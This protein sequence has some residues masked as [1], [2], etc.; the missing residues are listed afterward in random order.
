VYT[1]V[2]QERREDED[3]RLYL[4]RRAHAP[5]KERVVKSEPK[6]VKSELRSQL[7]RG[8]ERL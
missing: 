6:S 4:K 2:Y 7:L 1:G 5:G 8:E 3:Q